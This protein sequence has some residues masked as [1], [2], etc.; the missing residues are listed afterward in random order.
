VHRSP[1]ALADVP[2]E[3]ARDRHGQQQIE[4]KRT[5]AE[6]Q[7][8][9]APPKWDQRVEQPDLHEPVGHDAEDVDR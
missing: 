2:P 7:R 9:V 3:Q 6:P 5:E 4:R 8:P 1:V